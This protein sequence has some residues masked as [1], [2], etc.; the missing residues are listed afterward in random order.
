M[1][2]VSHIRY[3]RLVN[4]LD[5]TIPEDELNRLKY[6]YQKGVRTLNGG[7]FRG[8]ESSDSRVATYNNTRENDQEIRAWYERAR[9]LAEKEASQND[10]PGDRE[11]GGAVTA[12]VP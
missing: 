2:P 7:T 5:R 12:S 3:R 10:H 6:M 4:L 8:F 9:T 11:A 1:P